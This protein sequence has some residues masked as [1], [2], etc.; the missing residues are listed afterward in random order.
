[1]KKMSTSAQKRG[2]RFA[3]K[4]VFATV[5]GGTLFRGETFV[6]WPEKR[7]TGLLL[8]RGWEEAPPER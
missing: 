2:Q 4:N 1:M 3:W 6:G 5:Q 8:S 7:R